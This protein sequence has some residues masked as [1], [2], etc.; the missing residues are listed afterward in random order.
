MDIPPECQTWKTMMESGAREV[1]ASI[2]KDSCLEK[3]VETAFFARLAARKSFSTP[4]DAWLFAGKIVQDDPD[5]FVCQGREVPKTK[6]VALFRFQRVSSLSHVLPPRFLESI[7]Y[8]D[9]E[10]CDDTEEEDLRSVADEYNGFIT[11]GN[12]M[13]VVWVTDFEDIEGRLGDHA[14]LVSLLGMDTDRYI[15][16]VL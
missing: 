6:F 5:R 3:A 7:G 10:F 8:R 14:A 2:E 12:A 13:Q 16:C 1:L 11:L 9:K 4:D 15:L